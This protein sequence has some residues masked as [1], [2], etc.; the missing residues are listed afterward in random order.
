M[1]VSFI[2]IATKAGEKELLASIQKTNAQNKRDVDIIFDSEHSF[3]TIILRKHGDNIIDIYT[4]EKGSVCTVSFNVYDHYLW[5]HEMSSFFDLFYFDVSETSMEHRFAFFAYGTEQCGMNVYDEGGS[6]RI[7]GNNF[8]KIQDNHDIF[9]KTFADAVSEYLPK[10]FGEMLG[11]AGIVR[12]YILTP[13][14]PA[15]PEKPP[16][17]VAKKKSFFK[18]LFGR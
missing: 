9:T 12:R 3:E 17:E 2:G 16:V 6:K 11:S 1:G 4:S 18:S 13:K 8:L 14:I 5:K 10:P 15:E 7:H